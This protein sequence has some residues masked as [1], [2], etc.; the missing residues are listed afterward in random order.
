MADDHITHYSSEYYDPIKAHEYYLQKRELKGNTRS[1]SDLK[2]KTKKQGWEF[3]KSNIDKAKKNEALTTTQKQKVEMERLRQTAQTRRVELKNRLNAMVYEIKQK[4]KSQKE[5]LSAKFNELNA[6][7]EKRKMAKLE[8]IASD[9]QA[10]I[11]QLP[12]IRRTTSIASRAAR[13]DKIA[14][15]QNK[16]KLAS[17]EV[18]KES[19]VELEQIKKD[20]RSEI[21]ANSEE[22]KN[23]RAIS[24]AEAEQIG[25]ELK[26]SISA[27]QTKY[28][29]LKESLKGKYEAIYQREFDAI[30]Q[31]TS[32][33][34]G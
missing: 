18:V 10:E 1:A 6:E 21:S 25:S 3:S 30:K 7:A 24:R 20:Q 11:D 14:E 27:A 22:I 15:I 12:P 17:D 23:L 5:A 31:D 34:K 28:K 32:S 19:Q 26:S 29:G 4:Q 9:A 8:K 33:S 16:A 2:S 13:A